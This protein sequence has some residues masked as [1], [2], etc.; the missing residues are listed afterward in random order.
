MATTS[1]PSI[2]DGTLSA[3]MDLGSHCPGAYY[4]AVSTTSAAITL[5]AGQ[6][7][8]W[9]KS[10]DASVGVFAKTGAAATV[11]ADATVDAGVYGWRGSSE[12]RV[13]IKSADATKTLNV[14]LSSGAA[15]DVLYI[16]ALA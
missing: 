6:Y 15:A 4:L 12:E 1:K 2:V 5:P 13:V 14:I 7:K 9:L 8:V 3:N 11:P 16:V 10:G